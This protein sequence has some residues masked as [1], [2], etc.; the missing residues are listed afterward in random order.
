MSRKRGATAHP[1]FIGNPAHLE[2]FEA[3][4]SSPAHHDD[5][6]GALAAWRRFNWVPHTPTGKK[7]VSKKKISTRGAKPGSGAS[8]KKAGARKIAIWQAYRKP[9]RVDLRGVRFPG[10]LLGTV[11]LTGARLDAADFTSA[12]LKRASLRDTQLVGAQLG[13]AFLEECGLQRANLTGAN[14]AGADLTRADLTGACLRNADLSGARLRGTILVKVDIEG[15]ILDSAEVYGVSA[16]DLLGT[17][18]SSVGLVITPEDAARITVDN[19]KV[20]QLMYLMIKNPEIR[21]LLETVTDKVVLILGRF[22]GDRLRVLEKLRDALRSRGLVPVIFDFV[23]PAGRSM[24]ETVS[25]LAK[26]SRFVIADLTLPRSV[27][28]ELA[29]IIPQVTTPVRLII[30]RRYRLYAMAEDFKARPHVIP[31]FRYSS[32]DE[33]VQRMDE[34]ILQPVEKTLDDIRR[35]RDEEW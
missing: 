21:D 30:G 34:V 32:A 18:R 25:L 26:M 28:H 24:T 17:P 27:P 16:W 9:R 5:R 15:A 4:A 13:Q 20:A 12:K 33:L 23:G 6:G 3:L 7:K 11:D 31:P 29:T 14:L 35:R 19:I 8:R 22:T 2:R 1:N 10:L